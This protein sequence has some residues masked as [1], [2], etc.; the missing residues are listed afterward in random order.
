M[1]QSASQICFTNDTERED[2]TGKSKLI[3]EEYTEDPYQK[4]PYQKDPFQKDHFTAVKDDD[5]VSVMT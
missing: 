2:L 4:D 1:Q 3:K 5:A